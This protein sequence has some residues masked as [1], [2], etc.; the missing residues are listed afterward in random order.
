ML[1]FFGFGR[2]ELQGLPLFQRCSVSQCSANNMDPALCWGLGINS[3]LPK[4]GQ[5]KQ[6]YCG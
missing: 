5:L 4:R 3:V 6:E 2:E 1:G